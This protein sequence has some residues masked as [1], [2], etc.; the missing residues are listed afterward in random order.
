MTPPRAGPVCRR[1][2]GRAGCGPQPAPRQ[3]RQVC[4]RCRTRPASWRRHRLNGLVNGWGAPMR[5]SRVPDRG[6][7]RH[8]KAAGQADL[9]RQEGAGEALAA[10]TSENSEARLTL[11]WL[12]FLPSLGI[13][14]GGTVRRSAVL[15]SPCG[16]PRGTPRG[17]PQPP[18]SSTACPK[19]R[20][21]SLASRSGMRRQCRARPAAA[22][23][24]R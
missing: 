7:S 9:L 2:C 17:T 24:R 23:P 4:R 3:L 15:R 18:G 5:E 20:C 1:S 6:R 10:R 21:C 22:L 8:P 16:T 19:P 14:M 13:L 11:V 12:G